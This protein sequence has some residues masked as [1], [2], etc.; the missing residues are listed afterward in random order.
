MN[1][2]VAGVSWFWLVDFLL[3]VACVAMFMVR[4][5]V[6]QRKRK[7]VNA[8]TDI[9]LDGIL[10]MLV[11][12]VVLVSSSDTLIQV[13]VE[14]QTHEHKVE[15]PSMVMPRSGMGGVISL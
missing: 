1:L 15:K 3:A 14:Q 11:I 6:Y 8:E 12:I 13:N 10:W 9:L 4:V 7:V 2:D 5:H